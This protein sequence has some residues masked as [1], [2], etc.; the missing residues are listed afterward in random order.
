M[1]PP[2]LLLYQRCT[3]EG[4]AR[5]DQAIIDHFSQRLMVR[6]PG[7]GGPLEEEDDDKY[8]SRMDTPPEYVIA[9]I[10]RQNE[11]ERSDECATGTARTSPSIDECAAGTACTAPSSVDLAT[12]PHRCWGCGLRVHSSVL[13]GKSLEV[14]HER[15]M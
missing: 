14:L 5:S 15:A 10:T 12:S 4:R 13:C 3:M 6:H 2:S 11:Q 7:R 1:P 8:Q 9:A